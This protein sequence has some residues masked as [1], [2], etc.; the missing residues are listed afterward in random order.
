MDKVMAQIEHENTQMIERLQ[1]KP[2]STPPPS[3]LAEALK[4]INRL[5]ARERMLIA[6]DIGEHLPDV[7]LVALNSFLDTEFDKRLKDE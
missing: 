7:E 6:Q 2:L 3:S 1:D 5:G 4:H